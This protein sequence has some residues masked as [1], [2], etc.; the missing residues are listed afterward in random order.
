MLVGPLIII[1]L[2]IGALMLFQDRLLYFPSQVALEHYVPSGLDTWPQTTASSE[3]ITEQSAQAVSPVVQQELLGLVSHPKNAQGM[4]GLAILFHGNAGHAAHRSYYADQL[5]P[6][7]IRTILAEYPGYGPRTGSPSE[8]VL[9]SDGV[10]IVNRAYQQYGG[11]VWLIG[12][13][14]GAGVAAAVLERVPSLVHG[15]MLITPWNRLM[16][17]AALHYP[18]LPVRWLL[19]SDYDSIVALHGFAGPKLII[20]AENDSIVPAE[21]GMDLF[22]KISQPKRLVT[23]KSAGHNDWMTHVK[24]EFWQTS[25]NWL[26]DTSD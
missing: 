7:G 2:F 13:S 1:A 19:K 25:M 17:V 16:D 3:S 9:I 11:P 22:E 6:L 24:P 10:D 18:F 5:T 4:T 26:I 21:L 12:E 23:I 14:L 8:H 20:V 15:I